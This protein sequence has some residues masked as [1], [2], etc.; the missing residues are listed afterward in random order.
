VGIG[1]L[2]SR[3]QGGRGGSADLGLTARAS[4]SRGLAGVKVAGG[5]LAVAGWRARSWCGIAKE[6]DDAARLTRGLATADSGLAVGASAVLLCLRSCELRS[7][8]AP[9][10]PCGL[11]AAGGSHPGK[12]GEGVR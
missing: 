10:A 8:P 2:G 7:R 12:K 9:A 5:D 4:R 6:D 11:A 3:T 1:D